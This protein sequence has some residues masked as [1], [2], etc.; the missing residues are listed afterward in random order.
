MMMGT[1][2]QSDAKIL[3]DLIVLNQ[4]EIAAAK[5][6]KMRATNFE[7]KKYATFLASHH[8][9]NLQQ[10]LS[11]GKKLKLQPEMD[12]A[13]VDMQHKGEQEMMQLRQVNE[14]DFNQ[15]F[16]NDMIHDHEKGLSIIDRDLHSTNNPLL[17][18]HLEKT[19]S[20]VQMHLNKARELMKP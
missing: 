13:A 5:E 17:K 9:S 20:A 19:K 12:R 10:T 16:L 3:G 6:A 2:K 4:N 18:S 1:E 11:L 14:K 15:V 8:S 7:V